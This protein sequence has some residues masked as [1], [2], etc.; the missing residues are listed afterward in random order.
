MRN[1]DEGDGD[2][3]SRTNTERNQYERLKITTE[4]S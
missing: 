4:K 3:G 2:C 1:D